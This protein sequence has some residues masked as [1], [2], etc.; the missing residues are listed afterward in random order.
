MSTIQEQLAAQIGSAVGGRV[1]PILAPQP[2][3]LPYITYQRISNSV[4]N[5][6]SGNGNPPI[7][8]TR[9]QV[10]VWDV[11]YAAAQATAAAVKVAM[12]AWSVQ[13]VLLLEYDL[14]EQEVRIFRVLLEYSTWA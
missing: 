1:Y 2:S 6:L 8:N 3:T 11:S 12:L 13:N 4:N 10:D 7:D 14:Y 9:F 5:V